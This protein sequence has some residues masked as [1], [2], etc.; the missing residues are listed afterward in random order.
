MASPISAP[1]VNL[2]PLKP[3]NSTTGAPAGPSPGVDTSRPAGAPEQGGAVPTAAPAG[4][5]VQAA[6]KVRDFLQITRRDLEFSID[7]DSGQTVIRVLDA[8]TGE[9]VRQIPPDEV[10]AIASRLDR[11]EGVLL[12]D[13]A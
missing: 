4:A 2:P 1:A 11:S 10:L 7:K 3:V 8:A 9:L 6:Q 13:H 12:R 5:I